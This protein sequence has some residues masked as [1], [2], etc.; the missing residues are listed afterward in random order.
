[1]YEATQ[2]KP[3]K[4]VL[5]ACN[6]IAMELG[7]SSE[8]AIEGIRTILNSNELQ[9]AFSDFDLPQVSFKLKFFLFLMKKRCSKLIYWLKK[10]S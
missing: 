8:K 1:M 3:L 6:C 9:N 2:R 5:P 4:A 7:L 10:Y